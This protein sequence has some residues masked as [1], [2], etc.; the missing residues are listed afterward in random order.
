MQHGRTQDGLQADPARDVSSK[1]SALLFVQLRRVKAR[2]L[3]VHSSLLCFRSAALVQTGW[4]PHR[5]L[6]LPGPRLFTLCNLQALCPLAGAWGLS[7]VDTVEQLGL[8]SGLACAR[9]GLVSL[10]REALSASFSHLPCGNMAGCR[11]G[12]DPVP[13]NLQLPAGESGLEARTGRHRLRKGRC[14]PTSCQVGWRKLLTRRTTLLQQ[15]HLVMQP[16]PTLAGAG[17]S[18]FHRWASA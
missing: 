10:H 11:G 1:Y 18:R 2:L 7:P 5:G 6:S 12:E 15:L 13:G 14:G 9:P 16:V 3:L 17:G 8:T 4:V